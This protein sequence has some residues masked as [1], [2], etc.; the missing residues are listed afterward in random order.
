VLLGFAAYRIHEPEHGGVADKKFTYLFELH[1]TLSD[2]RSGGLG[3]LLEMARW[4]SRSAGL[5]ARAL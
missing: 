5:S 2:P 3:D 4:Y 1:K